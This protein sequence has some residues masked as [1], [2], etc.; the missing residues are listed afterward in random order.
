[1]MAALGVV[2][3]LFARPSHDSLLDYVYDMDS[4]TYSRWDLANLLA[5]L[6]DHGTFDVTHVMAHSMGSWVTLE[7]LRLIPPHAEKDVERKT[8]RRFG[9]IILASPDVDL[10]VFKQEL[11]T[12]SNMAARVVL[13]L[14]SGIFCWASPDSQLTIRREQEMPLLR[15]WIGDISRMGRISR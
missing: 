5:M 6:T 7:A 12:A 1:M 3:I 15:S 2:P 4:A 11:P 13:L 9:A 8:P 10:D 14:L